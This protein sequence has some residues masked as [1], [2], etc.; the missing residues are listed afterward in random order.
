LFAESAS[1]V[2]VSVK[3]GSEAELRELA[4]RHKVPVRTIGVVGG[5]RIQMS[6]EGR[7]VIDEPLVDVEHIWNTSIE[8]YFEVA[9]AIA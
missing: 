3:P 1:R 7:S 9:R 4:S 6:I 5:V 8:H 2:V